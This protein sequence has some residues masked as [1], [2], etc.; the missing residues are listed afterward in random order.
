MQSVSR[1]FGRMAA[2]FALSSLL[3]TQ[4]ALASARQEG[5]GGWLARAKQIVV[6]ILS[7]IGTPKG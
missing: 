6:K 5:S 7:E 4:G 3:A 1:R 2:V